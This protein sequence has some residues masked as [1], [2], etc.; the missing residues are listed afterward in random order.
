MRRVLWTLTII[1]VLAGGA[2]ATFR[3]P[4]R[5]H[6]FSADGQVLAETE[7]ESWCSGATY[8]AS[9]GKGNARQATDCRKVHAEEFDTVI[10]H[11]E[12]LRWFCRGAA[13]E[14]FMG[15]VQTDCVDFLTGI[16]WWP[17]INGALAEVWSDAYPYPLDIFGNTQ[18]DDTED[19]EHS[20]DGF[21][22][23]N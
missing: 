12:V 3:D 15:D 22:R 16:R 23:E 1:A 6:V 11:G 2:F 19:R 14:G 21:E 9:S 10:N 4:G 20:R 13:S 5:I 17:T 8:W 18:G 7:L